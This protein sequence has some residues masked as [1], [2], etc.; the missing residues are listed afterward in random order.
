M[1]RGKLH[2]VAMT[3]YYQPST[4]WYKQLKRTWTCTVSMF[5]KIGD[6]LKFEPVTAEEALQFSSLVLNT[7]D[8]CQIK[9]MLTTF[10]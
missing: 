2:V 8:V 7:Y 6:Y 4:R 5:C 1:V 3:T 9:N 10:K